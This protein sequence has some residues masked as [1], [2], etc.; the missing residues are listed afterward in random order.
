LAETLEAVAFALGGQA[1]FRLAQRLKMPCSD[2]TLLR[3][4]RKGPVPPAEPA[5]VIGVDD[6]AKQRGQVYGTLI[7]DLERRRTI[8]LLEDRQAE[9]LMAWLRQQTSVQVMARDRS[10]VFR[11]LRAHG[12]HSIRTRSKSSLAWPYIRRL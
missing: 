7:D 2:D 8:D 9:T 1:G 3:M 11:T 6:W 5:R 4:I 12:S 10:G